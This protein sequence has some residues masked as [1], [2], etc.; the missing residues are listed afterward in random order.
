MQLPHVQR[1]QRQHKLL[2]ITARLQPP[3][4]PLSPERRQRKGLVVGDE[5]II[6]DRKSYCC[7]PVLTGLAVSTVTLM[8]DRNTQALSNIKL[9]VLCSGNLEV[10]R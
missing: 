6:C 2:H 5:H 4:H 9:K 3:D 7:M 1:R 8:T 10:S